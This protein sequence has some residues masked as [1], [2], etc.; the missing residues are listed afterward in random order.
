MEL[1]KLQIRKPEPFPHVDGIDS[2]QAH[3]S[4]LRLLSAELI[5]S[6]HSPTTHYESWFKLCVTARG[7]IVLGEWPDLD[8]V[9]T[10]VSI[11]S[12]LRALA[13]DAPEEERPALLRAAGIASRTI[14][15]IGRRNVVAPNGYDDWIGEPDRVRDRL[16]EPGRELQS[17]EPGPEDQDVFAHRRHISTNSTKANLM[18]SLAGSSPVAIA[19]ITPVTTANAAINVR[20]L[21]RVGES[22]PTPPPPP[23]QA[24]VY[25]YRQT[26]AEE[27]TRVRRIT[28][29]R[30]RRG[31]WRRLG[32]RRP[33]QRA[34]R[35]S[36]RAT[37]RRTRG[38]SSWGR[39]RG[40]ARLHRRAT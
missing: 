26:H 13:E 37:S 5:G 24:A 38:P 8:R 27:T 3:E 7:W 30:G 23:L 35:P 6:D 2:R 1:H 31:R 15:R 32:N 39:R 21:L 22:T 11:H 4:L 20:P 34:A 12:L 28:S 17:A 25:A 29:A 19:R 40:S 14:A 33:A 9:A 10:A 18:A 36:R 16:R